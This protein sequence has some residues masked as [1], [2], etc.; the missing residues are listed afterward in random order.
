MTK[1]KFA[2]S[3]DELWFPTSHLGK[4]LPKKQHCCF[5]SRKQQSAYLGKIA[6]AT[7][8]CLRGLWGYQFDN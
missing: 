4:R 6:A 8:Q 2:V 7:A 1:H 5:S 3:G